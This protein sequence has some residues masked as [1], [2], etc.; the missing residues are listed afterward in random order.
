MACVRLCVHWCVYV[1]FRVSWHMCMAGHDVWRTKCKWVIVCES[2]PCVTVWPHF[3][4]VADLVQKAICAIFPDLQG[5]VTVTASNSLSAGVC[6]CLCVYRFVCLWKTPKI[7]TLFTWHFAMICFIE[8]CLIFY[9]SAGCDL[10]STL[11]KSSNTI[12]T[13]NKLTISGKLLLNW[14]YPKKGL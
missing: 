5:D 12:A 13:T 2:T 1:L 4:K 11:Y 10:Y 9:L 8:N 7:K 14:T 6:V 3:G